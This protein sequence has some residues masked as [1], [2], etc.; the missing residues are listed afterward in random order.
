MTAVC[1]TRGDCTRAGEPGPLSAVTRHVQLEHG[2]GRIEI[3]L[4]RPGQQPPAQQAGTGSGDRGSRA[5][6]PPSEG[7]AP[8][9]SVHDDENPSDDA[10]S[11]YAPPDL[12]PRFAG[13][14]PKPKRRAKHAHG[15][16]Q[17]RPEAERAPARVVSDEERARVHAIAEQARRSIDAAKKAGGRRSA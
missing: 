11:L 8:A 5:A 3:V 12:P 7:S 2:S 4:A 1:M 13:D 10:R 15:A 6:D 14:A 9:P 17:T 16:R